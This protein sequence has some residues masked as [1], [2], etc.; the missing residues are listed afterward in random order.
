MDFFTAMEVSA[1]RPVGR[2]HADER[3]GVE[4]RERADHAGRRRRAVQAQATS[5]CRRSTSPGAKGTPYAQAVHGV[6]VS[7]ITQDS[8]PPR[9]EYD[10]GHPQAE[11]AGLRRVPERQ[12][13][14]GDGRHDHRVARLRGRHHVDVDRRQH[15]RARA[16]D[17]QVSI[18][19]I[20][21]PSIE[22]R[23]DDRSSKTAAEV[24]D[25]PIDLGEHVQRRRSTDARALEHNA[26]ER[27]RA[28]RRAAIR[29]W[30]STK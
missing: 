10:P 5:S 17:R 7:Q 8:A 23:R 11:R 24:G 25:R 30:A 22:G 19:P 28:V 18:A 3:R 20:S 6:A 16:G 26:T 29:A 12:P 15:G 27:R 13:R 9:L 21:M 14:R 2:A 1:S 4:P